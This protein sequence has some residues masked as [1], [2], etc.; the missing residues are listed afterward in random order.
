MMPVDVEIRLI[1]VH[2]FAHGVGHP[3][4]GKNVAG[5]VQGNSVVGVKPLASHNF[6]VDRREGAD[7]L[8][9]MRGC[10]P[11]ARKPSF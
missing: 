7:R 6:L 1:A 5:A 10:E 11:G 3:A 4:H 8:S 9:G 2:A